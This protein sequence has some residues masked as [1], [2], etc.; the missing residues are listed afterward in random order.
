MHPDLYG[1]EFHFRSHLVY[2]GKTGHITCAETE[3]GFGIIAQTNGKAEVGALGAVFLVAAFRC[4][5]S[6]STIL[7][8]SA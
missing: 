3:A 7:K 2:I 6:F 8:A 4:W 1:G 5:Y